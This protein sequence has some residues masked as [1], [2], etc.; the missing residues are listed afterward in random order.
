MQDRCLRDRRLARLAA[1]FVRVMF[2]QEHNKA[3][4]GM[5]IRHVL[6]AKLWGFKLTL[7]RSASD[8]RTDA[9][10]TVHRIA[11]IGLVDEREAM[12]ST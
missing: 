8:R 10:I 3:N 11:L 1:R 2:A 4:S 5:E 7:V 6:V 9:L 12:Y